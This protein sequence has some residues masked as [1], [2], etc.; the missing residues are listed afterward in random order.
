MNAL[1]N[2]EIAAINCIPG[3]MSAH[4]GQASRAVAHLHIVP[5]IEHKPAS[6]VIV[7]RLEYVDFLSKHCRVAYNAAKVLSLLIFRCQRNRPGE[8]S[9]RLEVIREGGR[10]GA[11]SFWW[12]HTREDIADETG[13]SEDQVRTALKALIEQRLVAVQRGRH[14]INGEVPC[15]RGKTVWHLRLGVCQRGCGLTG[16]PSVDDLMQMRIVLDG[17]SSPLINGD[18]SPGLLLDTLKGLDTKEENTNSVAEKPATK[19]MS[20]EAVSGKGLISQNQAKAKSTP[21][22]YKQPNPDPIPEQLD[23]R[24]L[25]A[26]AS[27]RLPV[28]MRK[29]VWACLWADTSQLDYPA[30][31]GADLKREHC[32]LLAIVGDKVEKSGVSAR[33]FIAFFARRD[34]W[35]SFR[36]HLPADVNRKGGSPRRPSIPFLSVHLVHALECFAEKT[37]PKPVQPPEK[38]PASAYV[39][40]KNLV[41]YWVGIQAKHVAGVPITPD[42]LKGGSRVFPSLF[43]DQTFLTLYGPGGVLHDSA[44]SGLAKKA[45]SVRFDQIG[46]SQYNKPNKY[47]AWLGE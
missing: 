4:A 31:A 21:A 10:F 11:T 46:V 15:Y 32:R 7:P 26:P 39:P 36:M 42:E 18:C 44:K 28:G 6:F 17:D 5:R 33:A 19:I 1:S 16:W 38:D 30:S 45:V 2:V 13:L 24:F 27:H 3:E 43:D 25:K 34:G 20:P 47:A 35:H 9:A 29:S 23:E 14:P 8:Q 12:L 41:A 22:P 37:A 40:E